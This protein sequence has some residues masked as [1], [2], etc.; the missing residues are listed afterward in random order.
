VEKMFKAHYGMAFNPFDKQQVNA[1][2]AFVSRD[3]KEMT[4]RLAHL[5]D[6]RGIGVF[7]ASPGFGKTFALRCFAES[8]DPRQCKMEYVPMSTVSV[9]DFYRQF[10][11]L[12][13]A[14]VSYRKSTMFDAIQERVFT[15]YKEKKRP[16]ILAVDEAHELNADILKDL[17]MLM[18]QKYDHI[19]CF[20]L[21]LI[22]EP[23][24]NHILEKP[25]H[26]ALRQRVAIHYNF[27]GLG[28][29]EVPAYLSH[30]LRIA[31]A[32][33]GIVEDSAVGSIHGYCRGN[34]RLID[35]LMTDALMLGAQLG[36]KTIDSEIVLAAVNNQNLG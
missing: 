10:C 14:D 12:V 30:K 35:N 22:G 32:P 20:T 19:N 21:I 23:H 28:D 27:D 5:R 18:N 15:L 36:R 17:K 6:V 34:P 11:S 24:L 2:D 7:T 26:E 29:E 9:M 1:K 4:S 3:H 8:L 31:G 25:V 16:L 13:G 33:Q